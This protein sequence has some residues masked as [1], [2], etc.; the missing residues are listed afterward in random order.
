VVC[1]HVSGQTNRLVDASI[2]QQMITKFGPKMGEAD[3][4]RDIGSTEVPVEC[5]SLC[6]WI[7]SDRY[8]HLGVLIGVN[9][10]I[11]I[12]VGLQ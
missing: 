4:K 7:E 12:C 11:V 1:M 6:T 10:D 3:Q 8:V 9:L 2:P 5:Y